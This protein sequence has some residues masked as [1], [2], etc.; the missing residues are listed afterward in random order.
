[1]R[2]AR[3][4]A[5]SAARRLRLAAP[6]AGGDLRGAEA[7]AGDLRPEGREK[8]SLSDG[9]LHGRGSPKGRSSKGLG[10]GIIGRLAAIV[11]VQRQ[12]AGRQ[13]VGATEIRKIAAGNPAIFVG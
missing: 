3:A 1:M 13:T 2:C 5:I 8:R 4:A 10:D 9:A 6:R 7:G 11:V 12:W